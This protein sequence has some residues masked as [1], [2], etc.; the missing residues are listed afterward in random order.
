MCKCASVRLCAHVSCVCIRACEVFCVFASRNLNLQFRTVCMLSSSSS[1][2]PSPRSSL[3]SSSFPLPRSV[4]VRA[5]LRFFGKVSQEAA[6][7]RTNRQNVIYIG[8]GKKGQQAHAN[9]PLYIDGTHELSFNSRF[10]AAF[11]VRP[12]PKPKP[13]AEQV[14][15]TE[16]QT[17]PPKKQKTEKDSLAGH[18]QC[19]RLGPPRH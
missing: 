3:T 5:R 16:T 4:S 13:P 17:R 19:Y 10:C 8:D 1:S 18:G 6:I 11:M 9:L 12:V 15:V 14:T 7:K 2:I